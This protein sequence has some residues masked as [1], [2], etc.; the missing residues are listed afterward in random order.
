MKWFRPL[1]PALAVLF[2][3]VG[4]AEAHEHFFET[5]LSGANEAVPNLSLGI[6]TSMVTLDLDLIT[7]R[8]ELSFSGLSGVVT[9]ATLYGP[10]LIAGAGT[11]SAM[12]PAFTSTSPAFP[13]GVTAGSYDFTFDLTGVSGYDPGFIT[14]SGGTV[15][16][17]LNALDAAFGEG[18]V[19]LNIQTT[20]FPTGE[21]RGFFVETPE[22]A[23]VALLAIGG[24]IV[25][26]NRRRAAVRLV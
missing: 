6:G 21:I 16:D 25:L 4:S 5:T 10:T 20:T 1:R 23:S 13:S 17:A 12:S 2:S 15:S 11:A 24:G 14:A 9:G 8:V 19:Y 26:R 3:A 18:T 7:L 22:P